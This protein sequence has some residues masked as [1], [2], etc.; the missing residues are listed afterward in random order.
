MTYILIVRM[1]DIPIPKIKLHTK[2]EGRR[3]VGRPKLSWLDDVE[4][5]IKSVDIVAC[6]LVVGQRP[7]DEQICNSRY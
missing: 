2:S 4:A 3:G 5:D 1:E 6:R 7:R